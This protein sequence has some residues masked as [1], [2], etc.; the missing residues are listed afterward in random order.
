MTTQASAGT[1]HTV[2]MHTCTS[3]GNPGNIA[4]TAVLKT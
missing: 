2:T 4:R 1:T 3:G